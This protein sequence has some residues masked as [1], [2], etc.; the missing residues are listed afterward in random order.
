MENRKNNR[1]KNITNIDVFILSLSFGTQES[2]SE[3]IRQREVTHGEALPQFV[4][5]VS[6][7]IFVKEK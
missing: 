5:R 1:P 3:D 2:I 6:V 4:L 7:K